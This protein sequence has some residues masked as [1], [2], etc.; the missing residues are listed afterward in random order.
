MLSMCFSYAYLFKSENLLHSYLP[1]LEYTLHF[2]LWFSLHAIAHQTNSFL[3]TCN[4]AFTNP[5]LSRASQKC[6]YLWKDLPNMPYT[7]RN[8]MFS[9]IFQSSNRLNCLDYWHVFLLHI[10]E[11]IYWCSEQSTKHSNAGRCL[12]KQLV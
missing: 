3:P 1:L 8:Y 10:E 4:L 11:S 9:P 2:Y 6:F 12:L 5:P 7:P